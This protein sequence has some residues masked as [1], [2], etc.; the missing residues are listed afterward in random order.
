VSENAAIRVES[1]TVSVHD[2]RL[3]GP[4]SFSIPVG[5]ML[6]VMG[7]TGAGKSLIAQA[8]L[9]ALPRGLTGTGKIWLAGERIDAL[10]PAARARLWGRRIAMLPQEPWR[11]LDPLMEAALQV[12]E[13][14]R[15]VRGLRS[16]AAA[17]AANADFA[18]LGLVGA[19]RRLPG[20]LSGGMAQRVAFAAAKAGQAPILVADEPT[21]GLDADRR[22][23]VIDLLARVPAEGGALL[24]ITHHIDV[25]RQLGGELLILKD[26]AVVEAGATAAVLKSPAARYTRALIAAAPE[27]WHRPPSMPPGNTLLAAHGIAVE[28]GGHRLF[29]G[30]NLAIRA[31]ERVAVTGPS[32]AGKTSLLDVFAGLLR[33]A[34][35]E[36]WRAPVVGRTGVQKLYQ[37]PPAAFPPRL[38]LRRALADVARLHRVEWDRAV[39]LLEQLKID[40]ALLD[41]R[42]DAV[43]GGELQRIALARVLLIA[44]A[45]VL[46]DEP[47]SRLDPIIQSEIMSLIAEVTT[48]EKTAL[49]L[50]T[51]DHTIAENWADRQIDLTAK[52]SY[53]GA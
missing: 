41:R 48:R 26:G 49:V 45:V 32:G 7:E 2:R 47:T 34:E 24:T 4:I 13:T 40:L 52:P 28:R 21:K 36:V 25:A 30:L 20:A 11:A 39:E 35:G 31:G 22:D 29:Q 5:D 51:H 9:G 8:I 37:D 3:V 10:A 18:A 27:A 23:A 19:E 1:L 15:F 6:I 33:P 42:P 12:A 16:Q 50:V 38:T 14:H 43:S 53:A 17:Y 46:A 44:P